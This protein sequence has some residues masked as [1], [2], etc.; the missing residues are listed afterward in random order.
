LNRTLKGDLPSTKEG[1]NH[2]EGTHASSD[3]PT[4]PNKKKRNKDK[5]PVFVSDD[6]NNPMEQAH[7]IWE[8][9]NQMAASI[10]GSCQTTPLPAGWQAAQD[11]ASGKTYYFHRA[12]GERSWEMPK[13]QT[14][15]ARQGEDTKTQEMKK[16]FWK[17]G[18]LQWMQ[19]LARPTTTTLAAR[20][21]QW[22]KPAKLMLITPIY[23]GQ[24]EL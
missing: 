22:D 24:C 15:E 7:A 9:H 1:S 12:S 5:A 18:N 4:R 10:G 6:P 16:L 23:G 17:A 14:T 20:V 13:Q 8:W 11:P 21:E 19:H 3:A 2:Q